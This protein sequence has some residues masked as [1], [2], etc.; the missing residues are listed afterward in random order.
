M[1]RS[2]QA[3]AI[4]A[5]YPATPNLCRADGVGF[6]I[7]EGADAASARSVAQALVGGASIADF[8]AVQ[9]AGGI[10]PV[11]VQGLPVG[12]KSQSTWPNV[13]RGG[14]FLGA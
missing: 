12:A 8:T 4:Y 3:M 2:N 1:E 11:A 5:F 6:V 10:A 9:V 14:G 13:T 7:A